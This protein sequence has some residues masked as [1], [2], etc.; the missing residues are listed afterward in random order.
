MGLLMDESARRSYDADRASFLRPIYIGP[1]SR[2]AD[3]HSDR[4]RAD[5]PKAEVGEAATATSGVAEA[6]VA[7]KVV[8]RAILYE[9]ER[10]EPVD[11]DHADVGLGV[12]RTRRTRL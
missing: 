11:A 3:R 7:A 8:R 12:R 1:T 6:E 2:E 5:R 9:R 10:R 4:P